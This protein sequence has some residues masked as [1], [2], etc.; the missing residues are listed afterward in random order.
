MAAPKNPKFSEI[1]LS[2]SPLSDTRKETFENKAIQTWLSDATEAQNSTEILSR[3]GLKNSDDVL[4]L[5][6]SPG[7]KIARALINKQMEAMNS[8]KNNAKKYQFEKKKLTALIL[9]L[10]YKKEAAAEAAEARIVRLNE[11]L[12]EK[13]LDAGEKRIEAQE[14]KALE[15]SIASSREAEE[16]ADYHDSIK[17]IE[18]ALEDQNDAFDSL[19]SELTDLEQIEHELEARGSVVESLI[20]DIGAF[21]DLASEEQEQFIHDDRELMNRFPKE[22]IIAKEDGKS[23]VLERGQKLD[24]ISSKEKAAAHQDYLKL[25]PALDALQERIKASHQ[26]D[27]NQHAERK[28]QFMH[29]S[30]QTHHDTTFLTQKLAQLQAA[31]HVIQNYTEAHRLMPQLRPDAQQ[32]LNPNAPE[33]QNTKAQQQRQMN[34]PQKT[35]NA[36]PVAEAQPNTAV[37]TRSFKLMLQLFPRETIAAQDRAGTRLIQQTEFGMPIERQTMRSLHEHR[38]GRAGA[39]ANRNLTN[40]QALAT[41]TN[42]NK[43]TPEPDSP[44][45]Q[46]KAALK[47]ELQADSKPTSQPK[48][49]SEIDAKPKPTTPSPFS[50][51]PK[52]E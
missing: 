27:K 50:I 19:E 14:E 29:K 12:V 4:T 18:A 46:A 37:L 6:R 39:T 8:Q 15:N 24:K 17:A 35:P 16:E 30:S 10:A 2:S 40:P 7:G 51:T 3:F 20:D 23:Y 11:K 28:A 41:Q 22:K 52:P 47:A 31:Q 34:T 45:A 1:K 33:E 38:A 49:E 44:R 21:F 42:D 43:W 36:A 9:G 25:K 13:Q 32:K 5:L 48:P 26:A